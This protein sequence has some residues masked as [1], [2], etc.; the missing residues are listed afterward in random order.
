ME[1]NEVNSWLVQWLRWNNSFNCVCV[2]ERI[3]QDQEMFVTVK[4]TFE[5]LVCLTQCNKRMYV[6][7]KVT[8]SNKG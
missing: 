7:L 1:F 3:Y 8:G 2:R 6:M 4:K 5:M